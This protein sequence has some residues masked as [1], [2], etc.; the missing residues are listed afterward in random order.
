MTDSVNATG[1]VSTTVRTV[2]AG[3]AAT[4]VLKSVTVADLFP[5]TDVAVV[6]ALG[7]NQITADP[8]LTAAT[9]VQ[10]I[11]VGGNNR[12]FGGASTNVFFGESGTNELYGGS[13]PNTFYASGNDSLVG[14]SGTNLYVPVTVDTTT[15][16]VLNVAAGTGANTF[17]LSRQDSVSLDLTATGSAQPFDS[18]GNQMRLTGSFQ[19]ASV[20]GTAGSDTLTASSGASIS[21]GGG[22]DLLKS[23]NA[24]NVTLVG[25]SG[26]NTSLVAGGGI[27][28]S[29][30]GGSG[31]NASLI[32][33]A[34]SLNVSLVAGPGATRPSSPGLVA[35][36]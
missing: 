15:G 13:G 7:F 20:L 17:D 12:F 27:N 23:N 22:S 26:N 2:A 33:G 18:F 5:D 3:T 28:V 30:V 32:A 21:G 8:S 25:G 9:T 11:A 31:N 1:Q 4:P 34:G 19:S 36:T 29:L 16:N 24:N 35:P 6:L 10:F 14:G